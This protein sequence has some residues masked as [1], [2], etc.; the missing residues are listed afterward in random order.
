MTTMTRSNERDNGEGSAAEIAALHVRLLTARPTPQDVTDLW[1]AIDR[2]VARL[3]E[4]ARPGTFKMLESRAPD[5]GMLISTPDKLTYWPLD[6]PLPSAEYAAGNAVQERVDHDHVAVVVKPLGAWRAW[7]LGRAGTV[8]AVREDHCAAPRSPFTFVR[9]LRSAPRGPRTLK[10]ADGN[11]VPIYF[12]L[13]DPA[14]PAKMLYFYRVPSGRQ[15]GKLKPWPPKVANYWR[16]SIKDLP[17][18]HPE[19]WRKTDWNTPANLAYAEAHWARVPEYRAAVEA[20]IAADPNGCA[21]RFALFNS[22]CCCCNKRL[23]EEHSKVYGIGPEC[24]KGASPAR[25]NMFLE[26]MRQ[27]HGK[28]AAATSMLPEVST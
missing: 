13:P 21:V 20:T 28:A 6:I 10:D 24:R 1:A 25:L 7:I 16:L 19:G 3:A 17:E 2:E 15:A 11:T 26:L 4:P 22:R 14:D 23:T 27:A 9:R 12:A 8:G 18:Q 5:R